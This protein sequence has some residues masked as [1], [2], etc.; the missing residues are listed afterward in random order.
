MSNRTIEHSISTA[1]A[2]GGYQAHLL[3]AYQRDAL[4]A[5]I[6][7]ATIRRLTPGVHTDAFAA[8][9]LPIRQLADRLIELLPDENNTR[10][11]HTYPGGEGY[12]VRLFVARRRATTE[13][14][15]T[16]LMLLELAM[17]AFAAG[18]WDGQR[19]LVKAAA[20]LGVTL[21]DP[22]GTGPAGTTPPKGTHPQ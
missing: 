22:A 14:S 1:A 20:V 3:T 21:D 18:R 4:A 17:S 12:R 13:A 11:L 19:L 8:N 16:A 5:G 6:A 10:M 2:M 15:R 7:P 9:F